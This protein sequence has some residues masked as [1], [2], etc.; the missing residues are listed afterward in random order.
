MCVW[1]YVIL[2]C[3]DLY[4]HYHDQETELSLTMKIFLLL[5]LYDLHPLPKPF[6]I[7]ATTK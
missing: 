5:S 6:L 1:L 2:S 7:L 3:V 4:D